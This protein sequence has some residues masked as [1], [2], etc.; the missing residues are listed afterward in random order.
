MKAKVEWLEGVCFEAETGSG[1]RVI[2]EGPEELGGQGRGARPMEL[3]LVSLGGCTA[4][5]VVTIL[6]KAR[7]DCTGCVVDVEAERAETVP[8]VFTRIHLHYRIR[9]RDLSTKHVERA[10]S[11]SKEKYCSASLMLAEAVKITYEITI[12]EEGT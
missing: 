10:V 7:Q 3:M 2:M 9:G 6:A 1:A 4:F 5:D 11:L 8:K 12:T